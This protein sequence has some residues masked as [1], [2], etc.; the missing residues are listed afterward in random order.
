MITS[1]KNSNLDITPEELMNTEIL[2][3]K[4]HRNLDKVVRFESHTI[5]T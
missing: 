1:Q 4:L 2:S 5:Y 3:M